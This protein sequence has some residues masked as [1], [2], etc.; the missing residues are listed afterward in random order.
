MCLRS[1]VTS[2]YYITFHFKLSLIRSKAHITLIVKEMIST[3]LLKES[4]NQE[5]N[6]TPASKII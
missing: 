6:H 1:F 3:D 4:C 5:S 2:M